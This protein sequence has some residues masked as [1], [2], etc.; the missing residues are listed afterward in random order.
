M[1]GFD[2]AHAVRSDGPWSKVPMVALSARA[3]EQD[4]E[5]GR[6]AGYNDYIVKLD[7][8]ALLHALAQ[9]LSAKGD[10]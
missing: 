1:D 7:R 3:T 2:F 4:F 10:A 6:E 5:R 8:E 9:T